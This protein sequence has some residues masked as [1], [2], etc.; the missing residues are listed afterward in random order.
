L[1]VKRRSPPDL[2]G[3]AAKPRLRQR[4]GLDFQTTVAGSGPT[5]EASFHTARPAGRAL[6]FMVQGD[7]HPEWVRIQFDTAFYVTTR[8]GDKVANS[9]YTRVTVAPTGVKVEYVRTYPSA[10]VGAGTTN[11][12]VAF[13]YTIP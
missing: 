4:H 1:P 5:D 13:S 9:G 8:T 6:T 7:S 10:A 11:G 2:A 3:A 12:S